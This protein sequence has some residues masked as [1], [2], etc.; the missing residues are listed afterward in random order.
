MLACDDSIF[1]EC[2]VYI[3]ETSLHSHFIFAGIC[4]QNIGWFEWEYDM[5]VR[6]YARGE[7]YFEDIFNEILYLILAPWFIEK[8]KEVQP[9]TAGGG[10][11]VN[12]IM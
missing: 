12:V 4:S 3:H 1:V 8:Q 7:G 11:A 2:D 5:C 9:H 6:V 10:G